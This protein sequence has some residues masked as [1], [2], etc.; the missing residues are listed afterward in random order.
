[1]STYLVVNEEE[2]LDVI[3]QM[4]TAIPR[5]IKQA[6]RI[7]QERDRI[8]AQAQEERERILGMAREE[9]LQQA[10]QHEVIQTA[11][12]KADTIIERAQREAAGL[13]AEADEYAR[14][15]L[16]ALDG[17]LGALDGQIEQVLTTVRNG[18]E[19]LSRATDVELDEE[20]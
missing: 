18:L 12:Q 19:R 7:H 2:I 10:D 9:A 15:V 13:K 16:F 3:D 4:R 1:M 14:E 8:V 6:E 20:L 11:S 5:E 17:Q